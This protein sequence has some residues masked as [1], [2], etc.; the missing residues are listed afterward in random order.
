MKLIKI[1]D[2]KDMHIPS[3]SWDHWVSR[4]NIGEAVNKRVVFRI[5]LGGFL[6]LLILGLV[7]KVSGFLADFQRQ[8]A[9]RT[10]GWTKRNYVRVIPIFER[11]HS[12]RLSHMENSVRRGKYT[13]IRRTKGSGMEYT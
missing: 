2:E 6:T 13:V 10:C 3:N 11:S 5:L 9:K 8:R 7:L 1:L 4:P 12:E